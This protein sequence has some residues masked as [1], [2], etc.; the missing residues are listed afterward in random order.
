MARHSKFRACPL[1]EAICGLELQYE[2]DALVAIRGDD[3]DPFSRGHICPKGNAIL[4]LETDPDRLRKPMRR[5]GD[6]WREIGWEEAFTLVGERLAA[7]QR[8]HGA[9][10][11]G[12]YLGNPN[13]HHFGHI[14]YLPFL[15]KLIR[16]PNV[17]S[18]S[19]VDQW[20]HQLVN[21]QMYG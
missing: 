12:A 13:V 2:G 5:T 20:P 10:S 6:D 17:F 19:S 15:L 18:A 21:A 8:E 11:V 16:T 1:C 7:I 9:A 4:D 3:A 14:A